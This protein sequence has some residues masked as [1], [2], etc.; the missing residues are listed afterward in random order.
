MKLKK[1][2]NHLGK[3]LFLLVLFGNYAIAGNQKYEKLSQSVQTLLSKQIITPVKVKNSFDNL[4]EA[5]DWLSEMKIRVSK[6]EKNIVDSVRLLQLIHYEAKRAGVD[7]QLVL[8]II[9]VES[10]FKRYAISSAGALGLMQVMPFWVD[11]IGIKEHNLFDQETNIR[12][13]CSILRHYIDIENGNLFRALGRYNGSLGKSKY[14][15][16]VLAA[17]KR[18]WTYQNKEHAPA[19]V[20][21]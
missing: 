17:L 18:N 6:F 8:A 19:V 10:G 12:Y 15:N 14:P 1:I 9:E 21:R 2:F 3:I 4:G 11:L 5:I 16:A 7:P 13:G 20:T